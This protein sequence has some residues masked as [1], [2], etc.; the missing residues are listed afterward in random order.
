M[1]V[2]PG[3]IRRDPVL[4][5]CSL[6]A[7]GLWT[8]IWWLAHEGEPYGSLRIK[9]KVLGPEDLV[10]QVGRPLREV[11]RAWNELLERQ[12]PTVLS[13]YAQ[14]LEDVRLDELYWLRPASLR[15]FDVWRAAKDEQQALLSF[16]QGDPRG[17]GNPVENLRKPVENAA[18]TPPVT[19]HFIGQLPGVSP[20]GLPESSLAGCWF[21]RRMVR[22]MEKALK[23]QKIGGLGGNPALRK[24]K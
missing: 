24:D 11:R 16:P 19:P 21:V 7:R 4:R 1:V 17:C 10:A 14:L 13:T 6:E 20:V 12:V 5:M 9:G 15:D 2:M 22:D 18:V 23:A 8:E 3:D